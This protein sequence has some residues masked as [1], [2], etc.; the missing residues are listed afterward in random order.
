MLKLKVGFSLNGTK[1][2]HMATVS[3]F[4]AGDY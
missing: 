4:P 2:D 3:G 1:V